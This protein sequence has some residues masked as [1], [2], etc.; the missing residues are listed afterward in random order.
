M[1]ELYGKKTWGFLT[2]YIHWEDPLSWS[3]F[4]HGGSFSPLPNPR[5]LSWEPIFQEG[6]SPPLEVRQA[7]ISWKSGFALRGQI[8]HFYSKGLSSFKR[9]PPVKTW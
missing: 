1:A 9:E 2:T 5:I 8:T 4:L 3:S 6:S 7:T